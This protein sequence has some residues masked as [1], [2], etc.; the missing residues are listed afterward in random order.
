MAKYLEEKK[1]KPSIDE[2]IEKYL[3]GKS[4]EDAH[5]FVS[6]MRDNRMAPQWGSINSYNCSYKSRRV[7]IIK[8]NE[9]GYQIWVNTQ[10]N[11]E[12]NSCFA[13]ESE[14]NKKFLLSTITYC[15]GCG[16]CKPGL[17]IELLGVQ[18]KS[19]CFNPV[20][21][22]E[23]PD[24]IKFR[25]ARKLVLLRKQAIHEGKAPKITYISKKKR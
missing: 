5:A 23:N 20:I 15:F 8:V 6:F 14:E 19:V 9:N 1:R 4:K 24:D 11:E 18:L 2:T 21:R 16:S 13:E 22:L 12:F 17:D 25:L 7:C 10:Y 3:E